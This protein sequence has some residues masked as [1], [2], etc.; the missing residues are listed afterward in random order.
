M[1]I[2]LHGV[3]AIAMALDISPILS[4]SAMLAVCKFLHLQLNLSAGRA[5]DAIALF[6]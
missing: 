5:A 4:I 2:K 6:G 3:S 1:S